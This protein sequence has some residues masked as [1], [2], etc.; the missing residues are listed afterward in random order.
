A[1][2][3][4]A[5]AGRPRVRVHRRLVA[6]DAPAPDGYGLKPVPPPAGGGGVGS[7]AGAIAPGVVLAPVP[8]STRGAP[9]SRIAS[10]TSKNCSSVKLPTRA[11]I[12]DGKDCTRRL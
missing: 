4:D 10:S 8:K 12:I 3:H 1:E 2:T 9:A 5:G 6:R 7:G 11:T